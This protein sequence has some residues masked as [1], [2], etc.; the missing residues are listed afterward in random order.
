MLQIA[1]VGFANNASFAAQQN[2]DAMRGLTRNASPNSDSK[3]LLGFENRLNSD[4][5]KNGIASNAYEL[6]EQS[7]KKVRDE[8]IKR[9]FDTFA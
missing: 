8:N 1:N 4:K 7:Q 2:S 9:S 5:I 6:M 3:A